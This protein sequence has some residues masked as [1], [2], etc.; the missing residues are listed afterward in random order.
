MNCAGIF[1]PKRERETLRNTHKTIK[2]KRR[3]KRRKWRKKN[4]PFGHMLSPYTEIHCCWCSVW[5]FFSC[6]LSYKRFFNNT[7]TYTNDGV[8][9][10]TTAQQLNNRKIKIISQQ[11]NLV[12]Y[13]LLFAF[14]FIYIFCFPPFFYPFRIPMGYSA[15]AHIR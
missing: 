14:F 2:F 11:V 7:D 5:L 1:D 10:I 9:P 4:Q 13:L 15:A 6:F 12:V 3:R 8:R